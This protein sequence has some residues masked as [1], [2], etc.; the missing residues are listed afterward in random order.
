MIFI[1]KIETERSR[2]DAGGEGM[3]GM[4]G[5]EYEG[6]FTPDDFFQF[7]AEASQ[8]HNFGGYGYEMPGM[9]P[10]P[11]FAFRDGSGNGP[12]PPPPKGKAGGKTADG[13]VDFPIS[14]EELYKGKVVKFTSTRSKLCESCKG[15][16]GRP[17]TKPK[18]CAKCVGAGYVKQPFSLSPGITSSKFVEC[19]SCRGRGELFREK[20]RCKPCKGTGL[21]DE[22]KILEAYIPKGARDGHKIVLEG[23]ADEEFGKKTGAVIIEVKQKVH[24]VFQRKH[25]DLYATIKISLAEAIS[26]LSRV[27][28]RHLDGRGIRINTPPGTVI[29][30]NQVIKVPG[31]G[32]PIRKS[33]RCG[34]M[35]LNVNI[36]FPPNGW[37]VE[38]AELRK[39]K[40][41]LPET[42]FSTK[43]KELKSIPESQVDDVDYRVIESSKLPEY[44]E[45]GATNG[46]KSDD[47][48]TSSAH[49][50]FPSESCRTQ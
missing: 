21:V 17:K 18:T 46:M 35:Y 13:H 30:P 41:M 50:H 38:T 2:Y 22:T 47:G 28:L 39:L 19:N 1:L 14:L 11:G 9:G 37:C 16:T 23:E 43:E 8:R 44:P 31:E 25:E 10:E 3:N 7:F 48:K 29:R 34:D 4:Y 12:P 33:D 42:P 5:D 32:M 40:D 24:P 27:V 45:E 6:G 15:T 49:S 20:D 26:G 36:E